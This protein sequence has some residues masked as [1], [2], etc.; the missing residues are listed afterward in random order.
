MPVS[1]EGLALYLDPA[2]Q[3]A[4]VLSVSVSVSVS[5]TLHMSTPM[6]SSTICLATFGASFPLSDQSN[7]LLHVHFDL[8]EAMSGK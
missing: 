3:H 2:H 1:A 4:L 8:L 7:M 5:V 6:T